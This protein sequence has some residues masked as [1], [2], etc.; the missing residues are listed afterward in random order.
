MT[1]AAACLAA[2]ACGSKPP[3]P[4][5]TGPSGPPPQIVC[6]ADVSTVGLGPTQPLSYAAPTVTS[7]VAP[8]ATTCS[9]AS[10][11]AFPVGTTTVTCT[12]TDAIGQSAACTLSAR[13]TAPTL[14]AKKFMSVGDSLTEGETGP[15]FQTRVVDPASAYPTKLN[16]LLNGAFPGQGIA[17]SNRGHS[18]W[19]IN[20]TKDELP[21]NLAEQP[22]AVMLLAGYNDLTLPCKPPATINSPN[23][24]LSVEYVEDTLRECVQMIKRA[25]S[26]RFVFLSLLTA[27]GPLSATSTKDNRIDS[28]AIQALN[29][30]ITAMAA[31]EGVILVDAYTPFVGHETEYV[32]GDG[33]HLKPAGYQALAEIFFAKIL[34]T[35]P[36]AP[37]QSSAL[38]VR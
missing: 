21:A 33:L 19:F 8:V 38:R 1:V 32:S 27:P 16:A 9:A 35:V 18:G 22:E 3:T 17:V 31:A 20:M 7:G 25:A 13:V 23:C 6:G 28:S 24:D 36:Q 5:P 10:G 34:A 15:A 29:N 30:R 12:A 2:A 14:G 4:G 11:S 26:V 37:P